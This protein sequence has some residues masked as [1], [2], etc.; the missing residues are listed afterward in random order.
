MSIT[1]R[2]KNKTLKEKIKENYIYIF[3]VFA[4]LVL[5]IGYASVSIDLSIDGS[6]QLKVQDE[7]A[8]TNV[9]LVSLVGNSSYEVENY[10]ST[11][12]TSNISLDSSNPSSSVTLAVTIENLGSSK[13]IYDGM[14]YD[15]TQTLFY[16]NSNILPTISGITENTTILDE[17]NGTNDSITFNITYAYVDTTN[18]SNNTLTGTINF[19]FTPL[20]TVTYSGW[21]NTEYIKSKSYTNINGVTE[22]RTLTLTDT[23][24]DISITTNT[25]NNTLVSGTDYTYNS[26][27]GLITFN[28]SLELTENI[29]I[30]DISVYTITYNLNGGTQALN[31][32]T[33]FTRSSSNTILDPTQAPFVFGGWYETSDFSSTQITSTSQLSGSTTLYAKWNTV[34]LKDYLYTLISDTTANSNGIYDVGSDDTCTNTLAYDNAS[35]TSGG[36]TITDNNLRYVGQDPCNYVTFNGETWRI[37]GAFNNIDNGSGTKETRIKLVNAN[38]ARYTSSSSSTTKS[39]STVSWGYSYSN[40]TGSYT[41]IWADSTIQ[42]MLNA[43]YNGT[44]YS[45]YYSSSTTSVTHY[46]NS[47]GLVSNNSTSYIGNAVWGVTGPNSR[48][49]YTSELYN[50]ERAGN[51]PTSGSSTW[52]GIVGTIYPSDVGYSTSGGSTVS[53]TQCLNNYLLNNSQAATS[54]DWRNASDCYTNSYLYDDTGSAIW[55]MTPFIDSS[56]SRAFAFYTSG[57]YVGYVNTT[58]SGGRHLVYPVVY[59]LSTIKVSGGSGTSNDPYT[60][61]LT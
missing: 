7:I 58:S 12:L 21:N 23:P 19:H 16:S 57:S 33:T 26:T 48:G 37:M 41:S 15:I 11:V 45:F 51:V 20:R 34:Y 6:A 22:S 44:S 5:S 18:T 49:Y 53:R 42:G 28:S 52:T 24:A 1:K 17:V 2:K 9:S 13:Q 43:Y 46:Y 54:G 38:Y 25:T 36:N 14:L 32:V 31:Q 56:N 61:S 10:N 40:R 50:L 30:N 60:L 55:T 47:T 29:T 8:I 39:W 35:Y 27:T 59:L 3:S 4:I